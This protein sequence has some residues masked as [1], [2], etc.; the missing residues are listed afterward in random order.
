MIPLIR[1]ARAEDIPVLVEIELESFA[2]PRWTAQ[3]FLNSDCIVA[4]IDVQ[5]AGFL[6]SRQT[7]EG[8]EAESPEREIVNLA[9]ANLFRRKGIA[10]ALLR[11]E[12]SRRGTFFLEVRESNVAARALY[13]KFGFVEVGRRPYYYRYPDETAIVMNMK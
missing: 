10:S 8:S 13:R 11:H 3:D 7:F 5:V 6:V 1:G 9:V 2:Q 4:E 12:L